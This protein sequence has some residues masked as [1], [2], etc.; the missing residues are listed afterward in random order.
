MVEAIPALTTE[1]AVKLFETFRVY[2]RAELESRAEVEYDFYS[3]MI[4][5]EALTMT[6]I[7]GKQIIPA[8]IRYTARLADSM[9]KVQ[10]VCPEADTSVQKDLHRGVRT[11]GRDQG[12]P[13]QAGGA[14]G[15]VQGDPQLQRAGGGLQGEAGAGHGG[16]APP[17][18]SAGANRGQGPVAHALLRRSAV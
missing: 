1:K 12:C 13:Q 4:H 11:P 17:G 10:N 8:I 2:T 9:A 18:G 15:G 16:A 7:A 6:N 3:K 14:P 5:I